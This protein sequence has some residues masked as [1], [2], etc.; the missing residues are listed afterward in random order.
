ME[1]EAFTLQDLATHTGVEPRTIRSYVERG[2]IPGPESLG[3]G[4]RYPRESLERLQV[5][6]L[7]R[8]INAAGTTIIMA[9]HDLDLVKRAE[10]RTLELNH[11][12]L[13]FDSAAPGATVLARDEGTV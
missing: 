1:P 13:V 7:L 12:A 2:I 8:D 4:A 6:Q 10:C 3:R 11:G 9:T 5:F